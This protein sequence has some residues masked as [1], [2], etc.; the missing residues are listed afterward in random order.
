M[1]SRFK[2]LISVLR[3]NLA[4]RGLMSVELTPAEESLSFRLL[5]HQLNKLVYPGGNVEQLTF[6]GHFLNFTLMSFDISMVVSLKQSLVAARVL[7]GSKQSVV[8]FIP[9]YSVNF[10]GFDRLVFIRLYQL[11][12]V[13]WEPQLKQSE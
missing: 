7:S 6:P 1:F 13:N 2:H 12:M 5:R 3:L 9:K 10:L 8:T 4:R 11:F